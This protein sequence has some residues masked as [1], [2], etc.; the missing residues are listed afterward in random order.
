MRIDETKYGYIYRITNL[1][2]NKTYIGQHKTKKN[3]KFLDYM[4]SGRLIVQA[5]HKYGKNNFLKEILAYA[6]SA[7]EL[8]ML[9]K[10][11]IEKELLNDKAEYNIIYSEF[12]VRIAFKKMKID[13][14]QLLKWYFNE[15][16][17]YKEIS[18]KLGCSEPSI[19]NYMKK[20]RETDERFKNIKQ[21]ANRGKGGGFT[22]E[23]R[24][25]ALLTNS[26]KVTCESCKQKIVYINLSKH[27]NVC[28]KE[29]SIY[30]DGHRRH[31]C[32]E[33]GCEALVLVKH[34][35]CKL[36]YRHKEFQGIKTPESIRKGGLVASHKRWHV[37]RN[38]IIETC[39][40]C[41]KD[42]LN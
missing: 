23:S 39:E 26:K 14:E 30:I 7:E 6:D 4:G 25:K 5:V 8:N 33:D 22:E 1:I 9:E 2:N 17:S 10:Q 12:A 41:Q 20:L 37:D 31:Y 21:G 32:A 24:K 16:M 3:E 19:Y 35:H 15:N 18:L 42:L 36:H 27:L 13:N 29:N 38:K 34:K 40:L 28:L 11:F